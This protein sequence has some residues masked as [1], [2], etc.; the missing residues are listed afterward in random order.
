MLGLGLRVVG[1][2]VLIIWGIVHI[3]PVRS[4]VRGFGALSPENRRVVSST[5]IAKA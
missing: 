3:V 5:W 1:S 4:V 2:L